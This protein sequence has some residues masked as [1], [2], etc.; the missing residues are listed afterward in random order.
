MLNKQTAFDVIV[1]ALKTGG[2]FAEIFLEDRLNH[3]LTMRSGVVEAVG[4][5]RMHGAGV[6]VF[7]GLRGVYIYTNDTS[8]E[9]LLACARRAAAAIHGDSILTPAMLT[10]EK[11]Q[12]I[13]EFKLMPSDVKGARKVEKM[14]AAQNV[15]KQY[16][17]VKQGTIRYND[18]E[19]R[20]WIA[21][22]DGPDRL[23]RPR[24]A[25]RV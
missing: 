12:N 15:L 23:P 22:S 3:S 17:D 19:Q 21:N 20:V 25:A 8:R 11:V 18:S 1:E 10:E 9:G 16:P 6:R 14:R 5:G 24:R 13:H 7:S 4:N 2:D